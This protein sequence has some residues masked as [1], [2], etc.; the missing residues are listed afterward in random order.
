MSVDRL[1]IG[2]AGATRRLYGEHHEAI[3]ELMCRIAGPRPDG[4]TRL[5]GVAAG[6]ARELRTRA[7]A[8]LDAARELEQIAGKLDVLDPPARL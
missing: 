6:L 3:L 7:S 5:M 4:R 8:D 2:L 1:M